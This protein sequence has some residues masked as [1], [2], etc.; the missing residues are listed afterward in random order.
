VRS[1]SVSP[2]LVVAFGVVATVSLV[3]LVS[4]S[5]RAVPRCPRGLVALGPRCCG[6]G[7]T[8]R[9]GACV[10]TPATCSDG[11]AVTAE[12][13]VAPV[14]SVVIGRGVSLWRPPNDQVGSAGEKAIAEGFA[15]DRVEV[16]WGRYRACVAAGR[17]A[18]T[19]P[20]WGGD[21]G[22]AL[23]GVTIAEARAFCAQAGGRL[24]RDAEW[25]RVA[26]GEIEKR[27]PWGDPDA[28][29]T[30]A[31]Y[32]LVDGPCSEDALGPDTAGARPFGATPAGVL[33]VAGNVAEF[34]DDGAPPGMAAVRGGSF[35]ESESSTLRARWRRVVPVDARL[36][37]IG[38]RCAYDAPA[39][40]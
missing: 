13:C 22:Q 30:R 27:Y 20:S 31:S 6:A 17:C 40:P 10:G 24:P 2:P 33:D 28:F 14:S 34:V 32:G 39:T 8:L 21:A 26:L 1:G 37:W 29:C 7:Q 9:D 18:E 16:T 15:I 25:L 4:A 23:S 36:P 3:A 35:A 19:K 12:G 11:L 38:F 5:V